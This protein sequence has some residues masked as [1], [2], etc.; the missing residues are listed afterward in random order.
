[1]RVKQE[2]S[3]LDEFNIAEN[4]LKIYIIDPFK[5][6]PTENIGRWQAQL[7]QIEHQDGRVYEDLNFSPCDLRSDQITF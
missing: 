1:M 7:V 5:G 4:K 2:F 6:V 3:E